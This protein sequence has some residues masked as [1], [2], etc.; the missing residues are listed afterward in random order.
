LPVIDKH[1]FGKL[2]NR[3]GAFVAATD[4]CTDIRQVRGSI[5]HKIY[6]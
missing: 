5:L 6:I 3:T 2:N 4:S 1:E